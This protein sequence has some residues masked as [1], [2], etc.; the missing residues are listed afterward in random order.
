MCLA[1]EDLLLWRNWQKSA[2]V[3]GVV[4]LLYIILEWSGISLVALTA[5]LL[6]LAVVVSFLWNN[7]AS[8]AGR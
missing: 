4:T 5:N 3:V 8:F 6:L 1:V 7:I 2:A